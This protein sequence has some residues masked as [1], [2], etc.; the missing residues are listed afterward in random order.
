MPVSA[1]PG[2]ALTVLGR[3]QRTGDLTN[4]DAI[5]ASTAFAVDADLV[6]VAGK[7]GIPDWGVGPLKVLEQPAHTEGNVIQTVH[8]IRARSRVLVSGD[9]ASAL[10]PMDA[11]VLSRHALHGLTDGLS[12]VGFDGSNGAL[13]GALNVA[14]LLVCSSLDTWVDLVPFDFYDGAY[15]SVSAPLSPPQVIAP[16]SGR[17]EWRL[18]FELRVTG[19]AG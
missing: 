4:V 11:G 16:Q 3:T 19:R 15:L 1:V 14:E 9:A 6:D 10:G 7:A 18:W 12:V 17:I 5:K 2:S 8:G 13:F